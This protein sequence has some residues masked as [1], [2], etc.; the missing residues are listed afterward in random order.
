VTSNKPTLLITTNLYP[1]PWEPNRATFNRQQFALLES[2]YNVRLLIIVPFL[3]WKKQSAFQ[4]NSENTFFLPQLYTPGFGRRFYSHWLLLS[5][6]LF[7]G[8][9]LARKPPHKILASWAFP[10]A[11]AASKLVKQFNAKFYFKVHGSDINLHGNFQSRAKQIKSASLVTSG[12]IAVSNALKQK[13]SAMDIDKS[14]I[15]VIYNGIDHDLFFP[16]ADEIR[17]TEY[18]LFVGNLKRE[19]GV[20]ELLEGFSQFAAQKPH[21]HLFYVGSG[22]ILQELKLMANQLGIVDKVSFLGG[23]DHHE[24]PDL[25]RSA[26]CLVLPSYNEGVPNVVLEAMACGTPVIATNVGGIPEVL[27]KQ[28]GVLIEPK[29]STAV[30]KGL[31]MIYQK[32]WDKLEIAKQASQYTWEANKRQ[33]LAVLK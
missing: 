31:S 28:C 32:K 5:I 33:L 17:E 16:K 12:I 25:M 18:C 15:K 7:A 27:V 14:K 3:T 1:L 29:K 13:L 6:K 9:W 24:L 11:V 21:L 19:K 26:K 2:E 20:F 30:T 4:F 22:S 23:M 8:K 10:D